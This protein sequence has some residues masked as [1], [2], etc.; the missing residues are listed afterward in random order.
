MPGGCPQ[1]QQASSSAGLTC[2]PASCSP[3]AYPPP[4]C[5][6]VTRDFVSPASFSSDATLLD[7]RTQTERRHDPLASRPRVTGPLGFQGLRGLLPG[8]PLQA[9]SP[10]TPE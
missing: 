5:P 6:P 9:V 7:L 1:T 10:Q 2:A 3:V 8:V 4:P